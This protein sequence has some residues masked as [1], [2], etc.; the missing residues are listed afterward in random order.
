MSEN[1]CLHL[2]ALDFRGSSLQCHLG[3]VPIIF[4]LSSSTTHHERQLGQGR[5]QS[6]TNTHTHTQRICDYVCACSC[7]HEN[8][9]SS[10]NILYSLHIR[11]PLVV[12]LPLHVND[13]T[14]C[15]CTNLAPDSKF[16]NRTSP[17]LHRLL[18]PSTNPQLGASFNKVENYT[19]I[20]KS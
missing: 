19:T 8:V 18:W 7:K 11:W 10:M 9:H 13:R 2:C 14:P 1:I 5:K 12:F 6:N 17:A 20:Q 15:L 16:V 3:P 4:S